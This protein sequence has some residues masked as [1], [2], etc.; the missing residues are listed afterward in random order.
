[1]CKVVY[2]TVLIGLDNRGKEVRY[3]KEKRWKRREGGNPISVV[4][5]Y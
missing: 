1:V 4:G 5:F 3:K 2:D